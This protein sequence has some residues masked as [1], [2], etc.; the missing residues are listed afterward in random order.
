MLR[1]LH[2]SDAHIDMASQGRHDAETGLPLRVLDFLKALDTI[3]DTAVNEK[4]DLVIFAGD[5]YKDRNPAPTYQREW[6]RRIM[7]LSQAGIPTLL[8]VGNHDISP[9]MGRANTLH[10]FDTLE[11]PHVKVLS[12]PCFLGPADLWNLPLQVIAFPWL[13]RSGIMA[14]LDLGGN[15]LEQVNEAL[16]ARMADTLHHWL[17]QADPALPVILTA[18]AT[19]QGAVYGAE[20]SVML[21]NDLVLS[22]SLVRDP[23][24]SYVALGHIHKAQDVNEQHQPPVVYPGS[25][26]RVDFGEAQD[27][28]CFVIASV[29][30]GKDTQV[31]WRK[32]E[33]RRFI[34]RRVQFSEEERLPEP[35]ILLQRILQK[36]PS[37]EELTD[38]VVRLTLEYPRSWEALIDEQALREHASAAFEFHLIRRPQ[39]EARLRL[40]TEKPLN[41]LAPLELLDL[42]WKT[43]KTD[44]QEADELHKLAQEVMA[45]ADAAVDN[46]PNL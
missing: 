33:G 13:S 23:R 37:K 38:A 29:E 42:Y 16:E 44:P 26:E 14:S 21:G 39:M 19:V 30:K 34:D 12:R 9:A 22:G 4:V 6:G 32:L 3:I 15:E 35:P 17:D 2:F 8:L 28:K 27:E 20:R 31:S 25:I 24:L 10:E 7:R 40:S 11:V 36:M 43:V 46:T 5:A 1:I 18:H 45:A 41:S